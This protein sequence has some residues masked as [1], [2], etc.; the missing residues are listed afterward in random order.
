MGSGAAHVRSDVRVDDGELHTVQVWRKQ[1]NGR[2]SL[3][4]IEFRGSS[5]G[6]LVMLNTGKL[7]YHSSCSFKVAERVH[8][9]VEVFVHGWVCVWMRVDMCG[10][11]C[12][13]TS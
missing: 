12:A 8:M 11:L 2:L 4:G 10:C 13:T 1:K 5:S 9:F 3:D 7:F 6:N